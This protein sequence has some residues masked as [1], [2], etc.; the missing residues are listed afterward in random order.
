MHA[1]PGSHIIGGQQ[2]SCSPPQA[3]HV[4]PMQIPPSKHSGLP[5]QQSSPTKPQPL[6]ASTVG[7]HAIE[8]PRS[9]KLTAI[10]RAT[11][12]M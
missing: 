6:P 12:V 10:V 8:R 7:A 1:K 4:S 5:M 9:I 11:I 2:N 3:T